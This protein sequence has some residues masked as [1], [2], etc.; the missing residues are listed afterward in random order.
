MKPSYQDQQ[1]LPIR[2]D[3]SSDDKQLRIIET[4]LVD[5]TVWPVPLVTSQGVDELENSLSENA[6]YYAKSVLGDAEVNGMGRTVRHFTGRLELWSKRLLEKIHACILPQFLAIFRSDNKRKAD[7]AVS[8]QPS[9]TKKI[10]QEVPSSAADTGPAGQSNQ[11]KT[12]SSNNGAPAAS[13]GV[14]NHDAHSNPTQTLTLEQRKKAAA[15]RAIRLLKSSTIPIRIRLSVHGTRVHDDLL[16]DPKLDSS[17]LLLAESIG[18]DLNL[19]PDAIQA[20]AISITEQVCGLELPSD[21]SVLEKDEGGPEER[22]NTSAA[23]SLDQRVNVTNV[24]HLVA[25]HRPPKT[26][27]ASQQ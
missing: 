5:K 16:W 7:Q 9:E 21:P 3:V 18:N 2:I 22:R 20:L 12:S 24:A 15:V 25:H 13:A 26:Q 1:L 23:W 27:P 17:P 14:P 10:K 11:D 8:A 19:T 6:W 4:L